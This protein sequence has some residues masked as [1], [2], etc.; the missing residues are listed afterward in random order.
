M[1]PTR[2]SPTPR[3]TTP[4][5]DRLSEKKSGQINA[6]FR[7]KNENDRA[8]AL[9]TT[10]FLV[11][12]AELKTSFTIPAQATADV[13]VRRLQKFHPTPGSVVQWKFGSATGEVKTDA[14]GLLTI[15]GLKITAVPTTLSL[16]IAK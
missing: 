4:C 12:P 14:T 7:W 15:P 3:P 11:T 5:P 10:L 8:D 6:F 2:C 16:R 9:E 1:K 13:S